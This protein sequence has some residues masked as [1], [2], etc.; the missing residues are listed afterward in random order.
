MGQERGRKRVFTATCPAGGRWWPLSARAP[1][2]DVSGVS[3]G[4][5]MPAN[6]SAWAVVGA[7]RGSAKRT[8]RRTTRWS[9]RRPRSGPRATRAPST[10]CGGGWCSGDDPAGERVHHGGRIRSEA[11]AV[12]V[13]RPRG[14]CSWIATRAPEPGQRVKT[15]PTEARWAQWRRRVLAAASKARKS[16]AAPAGGMPGK[17]LQSLGVEPVRFPRAGSSATVASGATGG[18]PASGS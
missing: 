10:R 6:V 11:K 18:M 1:R 13:A 12:R 2:V 15:A 4:P 16:A 3:P 14:P 9:S 8:A 17:V 7:I 5:L